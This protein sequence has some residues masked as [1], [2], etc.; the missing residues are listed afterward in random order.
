MAFAWLT[1]IPPGIAPAASPAGATAPLLTAPN[2]IWNAPL[3]ANPPIDANNAALVA[4]LTGAGSPNTYPNTTS[5]SDPIYVVPA[6]QPRVPVILDNTNAKSLQAVLNLGVPIPPNV[7]PATGT[8]SIVVINQPSTDSVWDFWQVSTPAQNAPGAG[9]LPWGAPSHRDSQ[10][11]IS[12]GGATDHASQN[13]GYFDDESWPGFS[14]T[15]W[16]NSATSLLTAAGIP[17]ISE[18]E[19]G[20]INHAVGFQLPWAVNCA[21]VNNVWPAQRNDGANTASNCV[22]EG[23]RVRLDPTLNLSSLHLSR[24]ALMVATAAQKYGMILHDGGGNNTTVQLE[25]PTQYGNNPYTGAGGLFQGLQPSQVFASFPW[26]HM[27][28]LQQTWRHNSVSLATTT[29]VQPGRTS[30]VSGQS[31]SF[32]VQVRRSDGVPAPGAVYLNDGSSIV[33]M[34]ILTS[35][36]TALSAPLTTT[37]VHTLTVV[38]GGDENAKTSSSTSQSAYVSAVPTPPPAQSAASVPS[39]PPQSAAPGTSWKSSSSTTS[40][41]SV[42]ATSGTNGAGNTSEPSGLLGGV[43]GLFNPNSPWSLIPGAAT[44][45]HPIQSALLYVVLLFLIA[46][47]IPKSRRWILQRVIHRLRHRRRN[48]LPPNSLL[49][50][51]LPTGSDYRPS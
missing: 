34:S 48:A 33:G 11:H 28:V 45:K 6:A 18:M 16:G 50:E 7:H 49:P 3:P 10:Y 17:L 39:S 8:D 43:L 22:P 14:Q 2:S 38:Y 37:G 25:D 23:T 29:T 51:Q 44:A 4:A 26:S 13:P 32:N 31:V 21:S 27:Q 41:P 46:L 19:A 40:S 30:I 9:P 1:M 12:W 24:V 15:W 42:T 47:A 20:Q 36:S 5:W 35:G